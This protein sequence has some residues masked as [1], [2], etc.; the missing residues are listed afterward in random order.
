MNLENRVKKL[1]AAGPRPRPLPPL[2]PGESAGTA[3]LWCNPW[4]TDPGG[5]ATREII[6]LFDLCGDDID[7]VPAGMERAATRRFVFVLL[8]SAMHQAPPK[9]REQAAELVCSVLD[10]YP[11]DEWPDEGGWGTELHDWMYRDCRWMV[12][13]QHTDAMEQEALKRRHAQAGVGR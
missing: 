3:W 8:L 13:Q 7:N 1:E 10:D 6:R 9:V 2:L 4:G 5:R 12:V 11:G